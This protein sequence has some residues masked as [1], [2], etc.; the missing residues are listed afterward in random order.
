MDLRL[1][2]GMPR[3]GRH[4]PCVWPSSCML[5]RKS[6]CWRPAGAHALSLR[7]ELQFK[8]KA[9]R[10]MAEHAP[11]KVGFLNKKMTMMVM[12]RMHEPALRAI[13]SYYGGG[14]AGVHKAKI[15]DMDVTGFTCA[16]EL[17]ADGPAGGAAT[18][19]PASRRVLFLEPLGGDVTAESMFI[20]MAK[21]A[22]DAL[23][24]QMEGIDSEHEM[25]NIRHGQLEK[26]Q[27]THVAT[28]NCAAVVA[29]LPAAYA[30]RA[31]VQTLRHV[32]GGGESHLVFRPAAA[33]ML[34]ALAPRIADGSLRVVLHDDH[35]SA[36]LL[37]RVF[38]RLDTGDGRTLDDL[39]L[40]CD[41]AQWGIS[42][43]GGHGGLRRDGDDWVG[44][45]QRGP[46]FQRCRDVL[47]IAPSLTL[48]CIDALPLD[49]TGAGE[50]DRAVELPKW[51]R[52]QA[53]V[54]VGG[55]G[56]VR[57]ADEE[58]SDNSRDGSPL[59]AAGG[60]ERALGTATRRI[61]ATL[62]DAA[63]TSCL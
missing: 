35:R 45:R 25:V 17:A 48:H 27:R 34:R 10:P 46:S 11:A 58:D 30:G 8:T 28:L 12:N 54:L 1:Q 42:Q 50:R 63:R 26:G 20:G 36:T 61:L 19:L 59:W 62:A 14:G 43:C 15:L 23:A 5:Q 49:Y 38:R 52:A 24:G 6:P 21:K 29:E 32:E 9:Q 18:T 31:G 4:G 44:E 60:D 16:L 13:V 47:A 2:P 7:E 22:T 53:E 41:A 40:S 39:G 37:Q 33:A 3:H 57:P 55:G 51:G 56:G